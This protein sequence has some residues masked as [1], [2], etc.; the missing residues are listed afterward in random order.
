MSENQGHIYGELESIKFDHRR[1][2][3]NKYLE[4]LKNKNVPIENFLHDFTAYIGHMSLNR[5]F[6]IYEL[7]KKR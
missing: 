1:K 6:T 4:F 7:Y 2:S 5:L 3:Y